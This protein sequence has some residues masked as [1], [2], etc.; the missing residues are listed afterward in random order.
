MGRPRKEQPIT[1]PQAKTFGFVVMIQCAETIDSE[2]IKGILEK[3]FFPSADSEDATWADIEKVTVGP[4][5]QVD[6][7]KEQPVKQNKKQ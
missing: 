4:L 5:G 6:F 2:D 1:E 3:E 7:D